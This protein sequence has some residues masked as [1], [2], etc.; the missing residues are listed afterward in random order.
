MYQCSWQEAVDLLL[1]G[2]FRWFF[3]KRLRITLIGDSVKINQTPV[4]L[5]DQQLQ[6]KYFILV[7]S[8]SWWRTGIRNIQGV[9]DFLWDRRMSQVFF[10][11]A[12]PRMS[13]IS[14]CS[15]PGHFVCNRIIR[16]SLNDFIKEQPVAWKNS[17]L[18]FCLQYPEYRYMD[19]MTETGC[20]HPF[21]VWT[22][23]VWRLLYIQCRKLTVQLGLLKQPEHYQS[24]PWMKFI[25]ASLCHPVCPILS[26]RYST[27]CQDSLHCNTS[28]S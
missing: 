18:I 7:R 25:L 17:C 3:R 27:Q 1:A 21:K 9:P 16:N 11:G 6:V 13:R 20:D 26:C 22:I 10:L 4:E 15:C 8:S 19:L 14:N 24:L 5:N 23:S 2:N 28:L 12:P